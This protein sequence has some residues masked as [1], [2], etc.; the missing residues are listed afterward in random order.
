MKRLSTIIGSLLIANSSIATAADYK[1]YTDDGSNILDKPVI[2]VEGFDAFNEIEADTY[3]KSTSNVIKGY[4][5][6]I[7]ANFRNWLANS[8]RD[9]VIITFTN[10]HNNLKDL[11][12]EFQDALQDINAEKVGN[13]PNAVIGYS[14]GGLIARWGLKTMENDGVDHETSLYISY[15]TP[16]RGATLP[17]SIVDGIKDLKDKIPSLGETSNLKK[18][19]RVVNAH[20]V[21]QMRIGGAYSSFLEEIEDL[22]YP[23]NL[24]RMAVANGSDDGVKISLPL[25]AVVFDYKV[26]IS[27]VSNEYQ[28]IKQESQYPCDYP[29]DP[30]RNTD[31]DRAPGGTRN[32]FQQYWNSVE[33]ADGVFFDLDVYAKNSSLKNHSFVN[34]LSAFD[35]KNFDID[36]KVSD[37]MKKY[38]PFDE[39]AS[40]HL[41]TPH[42]Q[43]D[44]AFANGSNGEINNWLSTYHKH[45]ASIPARNNKKTNLEAVTGLNSQLVSGGLNALFWN[46]V[47]GATHY[48]TYKRSGTKY[49]YVGQTTNSS[50]TAINVSQNTTA[51]IVACNADQCGYPDF[52]KVVYNNGGWI[53]E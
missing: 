18:T 38:G 22:G 42:H 16:H 23:E 28:T 33:D 49:V 45:G 31:Y 13:H 52:T 27:Q 29:C 19:W 51:A 21:K 4:H 41:S 35:I 53:I 48:K 36:A 5:E 14:A 30:V 50:S 46:P 32:T 24:A 6:R 47:Q 3:M 40:N 39:Y 17:E 34:T 37:D 20:S 26:E 2:F 9:L 12:L 44:A 25:N 8:G 43:I 7:P 10:T 11:A 1:I 15:D